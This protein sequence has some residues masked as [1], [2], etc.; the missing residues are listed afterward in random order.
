MVVNSCTC[1]LMCSADSGWPPPPLFQDMH[2]IFHLLLY[3]EKRTNYICELPSNNENDNERL[4]SN[5]LLILLFPY[6]IPEKENKL[7]VTC[8]CHLIE[9]FTTAVTG[10]AATGVNFHIPFMA[11]K[12]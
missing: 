10:M 9:R 4:P 12:G 6:V 5:L 3:K 1:R 8:M 2:G 11:Q 7:R